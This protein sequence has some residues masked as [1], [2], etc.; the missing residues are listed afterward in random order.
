MFLL[1]EALSEHF[2]CFYAS[3]E[4]VKKKG[5]G[6]Y[7]SLLN[8]TTRRQNLATYDRHAKSITISRLL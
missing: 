6:Q 7:K 2:A 8:G 4:T 1:V 5:L 3:V